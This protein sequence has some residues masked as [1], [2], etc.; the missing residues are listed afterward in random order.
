M[1]Q[2]SIEGSLR[3]L[4]QGQALGIKHYSIVSSVVTLVDLAN[5]DPSV[6]LTDN[7]AFCHN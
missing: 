3:V 5:A 4:R 2:G 1:I 7:R 6:L